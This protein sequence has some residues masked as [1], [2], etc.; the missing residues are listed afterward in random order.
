M[1]FVFQYYVPSF[2]SE[3][4]TYRYP[5]RRLRV[6]QVKSFGRSRLKW[7]VDR[8]LLR[9]AAGTVFPFN[10]WSAGMISVFKSHLKI[11]FYRL[12]SVAVSILCRLITEPNDAILLIFSVCYHIAILL[13]HAALFSHTKYFWWQYCCFIPYMLLFL[14]SHM[15]CHFVIVF[16]WEPLEWCYIHKKW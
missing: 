4:W 2:Y 6:H 9:A 1:S 14:W 16:L 13:F 3:D 5:Q 12:L 7:K 11:N 15:S 8:F 10:I